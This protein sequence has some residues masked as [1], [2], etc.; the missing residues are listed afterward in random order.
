MSWVVVL[1]ALSAAPTGVPA[2][3]TRLVSHSP[4]PAAVRSRTANATSV[5]PRFLHLYAPHW[6]ETRT[7]TR[8]N[9]HG[10][11]PVLH[12]WRAVRLASTAGRQR[13]QP[14]RRELRRSRAPAAQA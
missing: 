7:T 12:G 11:S 5:T 4:Q 10:F 3:V 2:P 13:G 1:S 14:P 9:R 6:C 8:D